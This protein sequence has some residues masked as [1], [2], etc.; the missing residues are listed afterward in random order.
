MKKRLF[1][2]QLFADDEEVIEETPT[3]EVEEEVEETE[4]ET[5]TEFDDSE[6]EVVEEEKKPTRAEINKANAQRRIEAKK[7]Q[8]AEF[9]KHKKEGYI[10]G[11]KEA[12]N[13]INPYND[14]PIED[15]YDIEVYQ[16]MV[17]MSKKGLDPVEDYPKYIA[18]KQR[19]AHREVNEKK[20]KQQKEASEFV[21]KFGEDTLNKL[22]DDKDF[23][24]F[25]A[26]LL[27]QIPLTKIYE[28]YLKTQTTI[29]NKAKEKVQNKEARRKA[30]PGGFGK[31]NAKKKSIA[32]MSDE[33]F[34]QMYLNTAY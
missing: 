23:E 1:N 16:T 13:G 25:S 32:E 34:R 4:E 15:E 7:R 22:I 26:D 29:E 14:Q 6:D 19:E 31:G 17:E 8:E 21:E 28:L 11:V 18:Q 27:G 33:E 24:D 9:E 12:T 10:K 30:S 20:S 2:L 5:D 3:E